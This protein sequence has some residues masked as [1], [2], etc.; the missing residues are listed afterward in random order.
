[1]QS[2]SQINKYVAFIEDTER[3]EESQCS[4]FVH[5][6]AMKG[7]GLIRTIHQNSVPFGHLTFPGLTVLVFFCCVSGDGGV[8]ALLRIL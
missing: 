5:Q 1:M 2:D 4:H 3:W 8:D 7:T 6:D